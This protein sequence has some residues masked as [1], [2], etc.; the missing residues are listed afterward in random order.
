MSHFPF[1]VSEREVAPGCREIRV[2]GELDL[3]VADQ[4]IAALTS[5]DGEQILINLEDCDFI[6]SS[7]I[8]VIVLAH[9]ERAKDGGGRI[10]V[11][12]PSTQVLRVLTVTGLTGSGLVFESRDEAL[13]EAPSP[14][15]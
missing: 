2:E 10:V 5:G 6:D 15:Y 1:K 11:H 13:A 3:A 14:R 9:R 4:L 12:S 8:A 7:G